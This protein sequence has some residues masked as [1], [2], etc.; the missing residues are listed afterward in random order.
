MYKTG[1]GLVPAPTCVDDDDITCLQNS[2]FGELDPT[3][4]NIDLNLETVDVSSTDAY[5]IARNKWMEIITGDL[6]DVDGDDISDN[7]DCE[8]DQPEVIDDLY[9]CGRDVD[10]GDVGG[11]LGRANVLFTR[12]VGGKTTAVTGF[13]EFDINDIPIKIE[14]GKWETSKFIVSIL[15]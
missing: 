5:N 11:V 7:T 14:E 3:R 2:D 9:I 13:M 12:T 6:S 8:N 1:A 4:Y 15:S 10:L